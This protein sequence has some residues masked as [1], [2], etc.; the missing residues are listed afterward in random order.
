MLEDCWRDGETA[1]GARVGER[2]ATVVEGD[3]GQAERL[4]A[5]LRGKQG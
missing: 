3:T 1:I 4:R 5:D 2:M